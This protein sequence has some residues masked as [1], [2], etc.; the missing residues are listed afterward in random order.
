MPAG[1]ALPVTY[2]LLVAL[3]HA[4]VVGPKPPGADGDA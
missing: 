1:Q 2:E 4:T 3:E